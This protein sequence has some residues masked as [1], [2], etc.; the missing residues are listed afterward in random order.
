M[1]EEVREMDK[2]YTAYSEDKAAEMV[3][4][5]CRNCIYNKCNL[6]SFCV[7]CSD[8]SKFAPSRVAID[9]KIEELRKQVAIKQDLAPKVEEEREEEDGES[10]KSIWRSPE[11]EPVGTNIVFVLHEDDAIDWIIEPNESLSL[12]KGY[13]YFSDL[14]KVL[15]AFPKLEAE[16]EEMLAVLKDECG[17]C[18]QKISNKTACS[19]CE[20]GNVIKKVEG[21]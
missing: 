19:I 1:S 20:I 5:R 4:K 12:S 15:K 18:S 13:M 14:C 16:N 21:R 9:A 8:K 10:K 6:N 7:I 11:E 17:N 2:A 3:E